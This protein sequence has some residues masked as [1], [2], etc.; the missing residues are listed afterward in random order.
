M[1]GCSIPHWPVQGQISSPFGMRFMGTLPS[2][3]HGV[4]IPLPVGTPV[5]AVLP[6]RVR[7]AGTMSG[8]GNVIWL[9]HSRGIL[10]VYAHL[11]RIEVSTGAQ[12]EHRARIGTSGATGNVTGPNLHFEI[13]KGG[14]PV[15]PVHF[16]GGR[17]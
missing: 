15:D 3:H 4:D 2:V 14:R 5:H 1:A 16:L 17:P 13:W 10:S 6:G 12:V 8:Y 7:F 9:E 11:D